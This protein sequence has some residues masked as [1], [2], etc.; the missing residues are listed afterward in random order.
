M[1]PLTLCVSLQC[2]SAKVYLCPFPLHRTYGSSA[3]GS[4]PLAPVPSSE[5]SHTGDRSLR[6]SALSLGSGERV[7]PKDRGGGTDTSPQTNSSLQDLVRGQ[8]QEPPKRERPSG[9]ES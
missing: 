4:L 2:V 8:G 6:G 5:D 3:T 7:G 1:F 9:T